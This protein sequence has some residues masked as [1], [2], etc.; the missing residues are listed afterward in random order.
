MVQ[1]TYQVRGMTCGH[2][3]QSVTSELTAL[4]GVQTVEVDVEAGRVTIR[5]AEALPL[6]EVQRA[7]DEAGFELAG[8]PA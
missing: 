2:C 7:V 8:S 3:A 4:S 6:G 5:S 1:S